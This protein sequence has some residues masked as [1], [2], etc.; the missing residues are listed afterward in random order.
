MSQGLTCMLMFTEQNMQGIE[1]GMEDRPI[2]GTTTGI[3]HTEVVDMT[4]VMTVETTGVMTT[5]AIIK[6]GR[7]GY[8]YKIRCPAVSGRAFCQV[9]ILS[10]CYFIFLAK[11]LPVIIAGIACS[12]LTVKKIV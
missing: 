1:A 5:G 6:Q 10:F 8:E 9:L 12:L 2:T 11:C 3:K 7:I 4:G